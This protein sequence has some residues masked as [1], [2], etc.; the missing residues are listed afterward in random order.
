MNLWPGLA[1][2]EET[3]DPGHLSPDTS[4]NVARLTDITAPELTLFRPD[5][6]GPHPCVIVCPGG[7]YAIL[8]AD[9]EGTEVARWLSSLGFVAAVLH[10]RTPNKRE[11]AFQDGQRAVS[12]LRSRARKLD[13]D[14]G[15]IGVL[16]FSAGAHLCARLACGFDHRS[17]PAVDAADRESCRPDFAMLIYPAYLIDASRGQPTAGV[18]PRP[19]TPPLFLMQTEDD[20]HFCVSLYSAALEQAGV[21]CRLV[22]YKEGGHGY[23]LRAKADESVHEWAGAAAEWLRNRCG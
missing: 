17:Y 21:E 10:Y 16:G 12:L 4:N 23:G 13:L 11:Q 1:P 6:I 8:A 22:T 14:P 18:V 20:A 3:A 15:C 9:L 2:G 7:G 5:G 19:D